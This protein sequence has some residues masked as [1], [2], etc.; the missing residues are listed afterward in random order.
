[1]ANNLKKA[2]KKKKNNNDDI[3][4]LRARDTAVKASLKNAPTAVGGRGATTLKT[5]LKKKKK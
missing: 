4:K 5:L 3:S 1:M 2:L